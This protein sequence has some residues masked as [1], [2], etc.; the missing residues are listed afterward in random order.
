MF[1]NL[2][3]ESRTVFLA[4]LMALPALASAGDVFKFTGAVFE[5]VPGSLNQVSVA[6]DGTVWG[7]DASQ[8]VFHLVPGRDRFEQITGSL[9]QIS[10]GSRSQVWGVSAASKAYRFDGSVFVNVPSFS[11]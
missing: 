10:V 1:R 9:K 2:F 4:A 7:V 3:S 6:D 8:R 5:R 11:A